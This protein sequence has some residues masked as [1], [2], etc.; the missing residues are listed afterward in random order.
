MGCSYAAAQCHEPQPPDY[1]GALMTTNTPPAMPCRISADGR[2]YIVDCPY[3]KDFR[4]RP[5]Q[6]FHGVAGGLGHRAA[7]CWPPSR[8]SPT[9]YMLVLVAE[10]S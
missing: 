7:D 10:H 8:L 4:G 3:C 9:G 1:V 5:V 6:H 2:L